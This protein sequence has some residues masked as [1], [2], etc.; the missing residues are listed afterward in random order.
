MLGQ[1]NRKRI[2]FEDVCVTVDLFN[3]KTRAPF[4][5][6]KNIAQRLVLK[7]EEVIA[8]CAN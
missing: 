1:K 8:S 5:I 6:I 2:N 4:I 3:T 7:R